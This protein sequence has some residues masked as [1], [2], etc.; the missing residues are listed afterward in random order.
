MRDD[1][2][3]SIS[4]DVKWIGVLDEDIQT[5][6]IVLETKFGTTYNSYFIN[7]DKKTIIETVKAK[8]W[9]TY[10]KK[11]ETLCNP[12]EIEYI[13]VNHTEP[14]HSGSIANLL[15]LASN[16]TVVGSGNAINYLMELIGHDFKKLVIKNNDT[17]DLGNKTLQFISAPN[18]HW[19]DTYYTYLQDEQILFSCDSFG[20]HYCNDKMYNDE[21]G[22]FDEPFQYYFDAILRPYSKFMLKAIEKIRPLAIKTICTGHGPILR[23]DCWKYIDRSEKLA[24]QASKT[25]TKNSVFIPYV[26]AYGNSEEL[27]KFIE[28]GIHQAGNIDTEIY[29]IEK[30]SFDVLDQKISQCSA[31]IIGSPTINQNTFMPI[32]SLFAA[33]NPLRD[34]GKLAAAFGSYGWSGEATNIIEAVLT[35]LKLSFV[36]SFAIKFTPHGDKKT[37]A[38]EFGLNFGKRLLENQA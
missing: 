37:K 13:I 23:T 9:K 31:I 35:N 6:D 34:R 11:I 32:Y 8:F 28:Q 5:F 19:P 2:I 21:V 26:S 15:E 27:A 30:T 38:I 33:I 12:L 25:Q 14:D 22:N 36:G 1:K 7:A 20:S 24:L 10:L 16:A 4:P 29:D 3:L 17:L 18:L